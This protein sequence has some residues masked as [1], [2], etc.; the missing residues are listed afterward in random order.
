MRA[1]EQLLATVRRLRA[2]D[3]CPWDRQQTPRS[4]VQYLLEEAH[5]AAQAIEQG[6]DAE[7]KEE[8]GDL[9]F[10]VL[11][12]AVI[13]EEE[14]RFSLEDVAAASAEKLIRRHPH[15][16]GGL[17]GL[18]ME[19]IHANWKRIKAEEKQTRSPRVAD[20]RPAGTLPRSLPTLV[21]AQ[22]WCEKAETAEY[23]FCADVD[24]ALAALERSVRELRATIASTGEPPLAEQLG[25]LLLLVTALCRFGGLSAETVLRHY[26]QSA[27]L[28]LERFQAERAQAPRSD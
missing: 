22:R 21:A 24:G 13:A 28:R 3:G 12:Q 5:E 17:A 15:V 26:L 11:L 19:E 8:L 7:T 23:P 20:E 1:F 6:D 10:N 25:S 4:L 14:Q 9:L 27:M 18:S 16:F 2:P